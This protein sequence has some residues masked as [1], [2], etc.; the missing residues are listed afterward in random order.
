MA[1]CPMHG[2]NGV[3]DRRPELGGGRH[4]EK[5]GDRNFTDQKTKNKEGLKMKEGEE[6]GGKRV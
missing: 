3:L 5:F 2:N 1:N 6:K 4:R